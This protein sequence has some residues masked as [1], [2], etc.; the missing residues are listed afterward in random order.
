[1]FAELD[2]TPYSW[3]IGTYLEKR[4]TILRNYPQLIEEGRIR[5]AGL[6]IIV[7][8]G[9]VVYAPLE[10]T[11]FVNG[12]EDETGS[13]GGYV[14]L[15]HEVNG[16]TFYSMYGHLNADHVVQ[17]GQTV[18]AGV[19][20]GRVGSRSDSGQ[21]FTHTHLQIITEQAHQAGRMYQGYV[22]A[23]DLGNI[24]HIF[25]SPYPLFRY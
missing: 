2:A 11:V 23:E 25:P 8:E 17:P 15:K 4:S 3:G 9:Y 10:A 22:S 6:D 20:I 1:M 14:V 7:P 12:K 21:W 19:P 24:E 13:Y 18:P 5:H 16:T